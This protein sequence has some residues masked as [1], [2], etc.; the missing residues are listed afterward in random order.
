MVREHIG[1][2]WIDHRPNEADDIKQNKK[3]ADP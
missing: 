1:A 3:T 2:V